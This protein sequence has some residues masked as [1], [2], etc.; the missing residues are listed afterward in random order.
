MFYVYII[1]S[2]E[3]G[4]LYKGFTAQPEQRLSE[5]NEGRSHYT[6]NKGPWKMIY[7][8]E[9]QTKREALIREKQIKRY[10]RNQLE[11]LILDKRNILL[12]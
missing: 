7:L 5:H 12:K 8:E 9:F 2:Q 3:T 10:N 4:I 6:K 1:Q 11:I